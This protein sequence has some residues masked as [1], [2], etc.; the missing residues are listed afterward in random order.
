MLKRS[1]LL[2]AALVALSAVWWFVLGPSFLGGPASY[3]IVAGESMEP[4]LHSGDLAVLRQQ[5]GYGAGDIVAFRVPEGEPGEGASVIHRIVGGTAEEGFVTQGDN[6]NGDDPWRPKPEHITGKMWFSIPGGGNF[7]L[8]LRQPMI[9]GL[10]AGGLGMLMVLG[11]EQ[12]TK[13]P[14]EPSPA[15]PSDG[16]RRFHPLHG[17]TRGLLLALMATAAAISAVK[18]RRWGR[19]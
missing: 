13:R 15:M 4:A 8:R 12:K 17:L 5:D 11:G 18:A 3:I 7:L 14:P 9:L 19:R 16:V 6:K 10:L 1:H 2:T